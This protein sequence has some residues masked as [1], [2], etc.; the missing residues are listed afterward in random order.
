[1]K[2]A[3]RADGGS[4]IGMGHIMRTLVLANELKGYKNNEVF[5]ICRI[6]E[7]YFESI[8]KK[9]E[10]G[11][12]SKYIK[13][14][15][16]VLNEGFKVKFVRENNLIQDLRNI[17]ADILITDS[18]DVNEEYFNIL[19]SSFS[20]TSYIDD[21]NLYYF[22]VDF[23]INQNSDAEDFNYRV[24]KDT[25]LLLGT[26]YL[27]LREEFINVP[28]KYIK[29]KVSDIMIT[30]GGADPYRITEK[31]VSYVR[32]LQYNFHIIIGPSFESADFTERFNGSNINFYYNADMSKIMQKCDVAISA[33]GS[34]LYELSACG[35]PTIG[36]IIADNQEGIAKKLDRMGIIKNLG[37]YDKINQGMLVNSINALADNYETRRIISEKE[38]NLVDGKGAERI[39]KILIENS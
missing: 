35:V 8:S 29:E 36:I 18:Y 13:G 38:R 26:R 4:S 12:N 34:T 24:N 11:T 3:I 14:I 10:M 2:I 28:K 25:K 20:K 32:A 9:L 21:M 6:E 27:L 39:A 37:W 30:V 15:E 22:N 16:K 23:L 31:L 5:Y 33:C 7:K 17:N 19:K 1:M